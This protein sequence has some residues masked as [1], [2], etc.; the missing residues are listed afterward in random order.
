M[1][2]AAYIDDAAMANVGNSCFAAAAVRMALSSDFVRALLRHRARDPA[3]SEADEGP[4]LA[5]ALL[6]SEA[7]GAAFRAVV[8]FAR[9]AEG[10]RGTAQD[11]HEFLLRAL[12]AVTA[13]TAW[14]DEAAYRVRYRNKLE[15]ERCGAA[16]RWKDRASCVSVPHAPPHLSELIDL[17][18]AD[19]APT[20][21]VEAACERCQHGRA[22]LR[23]ALLQPDAPL[24]FLKPAV[25]P[26]SALARLRLPGAPLEQWRDGG[27]YALRSALLYERGH[28]TCAVLED[29]NEN[30]GTSR[31]TLFNDAQRTEMLVRVE[32]DE[33]AG[34]R[35]AR[36]RLPGGVQALLYERVAAA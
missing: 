21:S 33:A 1:D 32:Y 12:D 31:W 4:R 6:G 18:A 26:R 2:P 23:A 35:E 20:E 24:L 25:P 10:G 29:G 7:D 36:C 19:A 3:R 30:R 14:A 22:R 34:G 8:D 28:Y 5:S 16:R 11:A 13:G 9:R 15:C 27:C 17:P